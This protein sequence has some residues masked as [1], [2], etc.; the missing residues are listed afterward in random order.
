MLFLHLCWAETITIVVFV[1]S[2]FTKVSGTSYVSA[3]CKVVL[4]MFPLDA[5][6]CHLDVCKNGSTCV[7]AKGNYTCIC[8]QEFKGINCSGENPVN[9]DNDKIWHILPHI[10]VQSSL[11]STMPFDLVDHVS[12]AVAVPDATESFIWVFL[13]PSD[14]DTIND[15]LSLS[16][17]ASVS[18]KLPHHCQMF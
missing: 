12:P 13:L 6:F 14:G 11:F 1:T 9:L 10:H 2:M 3:R 17:S 16:A 8:A 7:D 18:F 5:R 4:R 15:L